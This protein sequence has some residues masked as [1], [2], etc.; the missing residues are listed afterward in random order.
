MGSNIGT[1]RCNGRHLHHISH[2]RCISGFFDLPAQRYQYRIN[3]P[4]HFL[5]GSASKGGEEMMFRSY[6]D[7][8]TVKQLAAA[9]GIGINKAYEIVNDGT[10]NSKRIGRRILIP[11]FTLLTTFSKHG[12]NKGV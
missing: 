8:M 5:Y 12:Y 9:L 7:V 6:P 4:L 2:W 10:I 3:T 11:S 1:T